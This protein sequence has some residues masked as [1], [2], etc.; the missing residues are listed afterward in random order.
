MN[1]FVRIF[2]VLAFTALAAAAQSLDTALVNL[3]E[4][5]AR[6][7]FGP[8]V[9]GFGANLNSGWFHRAPPPKIFSPGFEAGFVFMGAS[10]KNAPEHFSTEGR[11]QFDKDQAE[12][13]VQPAYDQFTADPRSALLTPQQKQQIKD[14]LISALTR[15]NFSVGISGATVIG[16]RDDSVRV[17]FRGDSVKINVPSNPLALNGYDTTLAIPPDSLALQVAGILDN[18][19][20]LPLFAPQI[21]IGTVAGTNIT[22]RWVPDV[23]LG[24][25]LGSFS[26][27]GFG[28]QHNPAVWL[29]VH[30]PL[31]VCAGFFTQ[32]LK[33]G[34]AF[35]AT[36]TALGVNASKTLGWRLL[37]F[38]PYAGLMFEHSTMEFKYAFSLD[39]P[40]GPVVRP[41]TFE[42]TGENVARLT[43]GASVRFLIVNLN[44]DV[45]I[46]K[47]N[48]AS[49]GLMIGI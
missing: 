48:T 19:A 22:L 34:K 36:A 39:L 14:S 20:A 27:F 18:F 31:D 8:I 16:R 25:E 4:D 43:L 28:I 17:K 47:Y 33:L 21:T 5:A 12:I 15:T 13:L 1:K 2:P 7:Y 46:A 41:V 45:S 30:M 40:D 6:S 32:R 23:P 38:T 44:A 26:Y 11:F 24:E 49:L 42:A 35:T 9:S 3:A 10:F 37:N 29:P